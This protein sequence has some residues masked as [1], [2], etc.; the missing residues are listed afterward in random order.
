MRKRKSTSL[1]RNF[2]SDAWRLTW[3]RKSLWIFGIF[4]GVISTGG[5]VDIALRSVKRVEGTN[6]L[7]QDLLESGFIGYGLVG[8]YFQ[9]L[10]S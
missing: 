8:S 1:Y 4:A 6:T 7:L 2:L 3:E 10:A 9:Q 5:V